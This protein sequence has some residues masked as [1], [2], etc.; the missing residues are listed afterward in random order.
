MKFPSVALLVLA[1]S[2]GCQ[3]QFRTFQNYKLYK[4]RVTDSDQAAELHNW[5]DKGTLDFWSYAGLNHTV[6]AMINPALKRRFESMLDD[7]DIEFELVEEN[8]QTLLDHE[9]DQRKLKI[10]AKRAV[11]KIN[12]VDF[13]H[14]WTLDEIYA[15]LD[16]LAKV[17]PKTVNVI[18]V[19]RTSQ[20]RAIKAITISNKGLIDQTRPVVLIDAG[21]HAREWAAHMSAMYLIHQLVEKA[22]KHVELLENTDWIIVP[23]ANPDGYVYT[24][25][26]NRLWRKNRYTDNELCPG[27]D[28]NRNFPFRW[29][30][31]SN[32]CTDGFSGNAPASEKETRALMLLMAQYSRAIKVYLSLHACGDYILYP[33]GY[34]Y[35]LAPNAAAMHALGQRA[36]RAVQKVEGP[37]YEVG[38]A[39]DLLYPANGSD[40][41]IYG[42]YGVEYAY[43]LELSCG[44]RG[45]GFIIETEQIGKIAGEA[46][47]M[48]RVF[49]EFAGTQ[50]VAK[51]PRETMAVEKEKPQPVKV[52]EEKEKEEVKESEE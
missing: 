39:A 30:Y 33:Y 37:L 14:F 17:Y 10:S 19:G 28:L 40:D 20:N 26:Q 21:I 1:V 2:L 16:K 7:E 46:F 34:D 11:E 18:E 50:T 9:Q 27:V 36:A 41:F 32:S 49:G 12:P 8:V 47:E 4:L 43:T 5:Y 22:E 3:A 51:R 42:S 29:G 15:Y 38:N 44:A 52:M 35:T 31:T 25:E 48:F 13:D 24:H 23:V 45:Y 6:T